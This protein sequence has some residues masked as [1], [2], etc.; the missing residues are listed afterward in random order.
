MDYKNQFVDEN[1]YLVYCQEPDTAYDGS[2]G[3]NML[4]V[5]STIDDGTIYLQSKW[6]EIRKA[7]LTTGAALKFPESGSDE[8]IALITGVYTADSAYIVITANGFAFGAISADGYP[9]SNH[10]PLN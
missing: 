3:G 1:S 4:I 5:E 10:S 8:T 6:N 9:D 2:G 7:L